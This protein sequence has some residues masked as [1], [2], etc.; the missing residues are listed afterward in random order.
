MAQYIIADLQMLRLACGNKGS[1]RFGDYFHRWVA[2]LL[3]DVAIALSRL[4][5]PAG[6]AADIH[7][8]VLALNVVSVSYQLSQNAGSKALYIP[9]AVPVNK[10]AALKA[11]LSLNRLCRVAGA[12]SNQ[13]VL[14]D[15]PGVSCDKALGVPDREHLRDGGRIIFKPGDGALCVAKV[16]SEKSLHLIFLPAPYQKV[17][18]F[19]IPPCA[20]PKSLPISHSSLRD[21]S[22][23]DRSVLHERRAESPTP[24][25]GHLIEPALCIG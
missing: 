5:V 12:L 13:N 19:H 4:R 23:Q 8:A 10:K 24:L 17:S 7:A 25:R 11:D 6:R 22:D 16:K 21:S 3:E 20:L 18:P 2:D 1:P 15:Q 14:I 9:L